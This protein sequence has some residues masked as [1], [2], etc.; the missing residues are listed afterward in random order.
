MSLRGFRLRPCSRAILEHVVAVAV[1]PRKPQSRKALAHVGDARRQP[2]PRIGRPADG[3]DLGT[4]DRIV[5]RCRSTIST[6]RKVGASAG[7]TSD[8]Y[9]KF[10]HGHTALGLAKHSH[11]LRLGETALSHS[12]LLSSRY[13]K[14]LLTHP[15]NHGEDYPCLRGWQ[16]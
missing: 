2:D 3:V 12:N 9:T 16:A 14:I 1:V 13:E 5:S 8:A 7:V 6:G 11:D 10:R 4:G 15:L